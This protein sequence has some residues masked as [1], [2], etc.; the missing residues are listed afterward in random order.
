[1]VVVEDAREAPLPSLDPKGRTEDKELGAYAGAARWMRPVGPRPYRYTTG[2]GASESA[3]QLCA[4]RNR[5]AK[6]ERRSGARSAAS[7]RLCCWEHEC[8]PKEGPEGRPSPSPSPRASEREEALDDDEAGAGG[9]HGNQAAESGLR[10]PMAP[11][12]PPT[13]ANGP[14]GPRRHNRLLLGVFFLASASLA[15]AWQTKG[16]GSLASDYA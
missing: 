2:T 15:A 4:S 12:P 7:S 1:M 10:Q 11:P 5:G 14:A 3:A 16:A 8:K 13:A 6:A 9:T